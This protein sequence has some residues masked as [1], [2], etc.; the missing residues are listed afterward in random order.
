MSNWLAQGSRHPVGVALW[1]SF[2]PQLV[3]TAALGLARMATIY[4]G[5]SLIDQFVEFVRRSGTAW[6]GLRLVLILVLL[7]CMRGEGYM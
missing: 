4:V 5:P 6:E 2:W 7:S 3:L 1:L